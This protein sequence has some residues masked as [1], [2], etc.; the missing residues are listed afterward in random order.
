MEAWAIQLIISLGGVIVTLGGVIALLK[1]LLKPGGNPGPGNGIDKRF[2]NQ[3]QR[4]NERFMEIA[5]DR[6]G[7]KA[8]LKSIDGRLEHI[9]QEL[10]KRT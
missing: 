4:C 1:G 10:V 7:V 6:G 2:T 8:S 5:E 3:V 9:E